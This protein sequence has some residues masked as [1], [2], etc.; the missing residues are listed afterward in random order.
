MRLTRRELL[1]V[2]AQLLAAALIY[3]NRPDRH[4]LAGTYSYLKGCFPGD[5]YIQPYCEFNRDDYKRIWT[6][7]ANS[8]SS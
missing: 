3:W 6:A 7:S 4:C 1:S 8:D 2:T 5:G